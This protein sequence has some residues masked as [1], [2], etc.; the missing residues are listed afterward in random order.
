MF[1]RRPSFRGT[2]ARAGPGFLHRHRVGI[3]RGEETVLRAVLVVLANGQLDRAAAHALRTRIEARHGLTLTRCL[4]RAQEARARG[5]DAL[6]GEAEV[7]ARAVLDRA[8]RLLERRVLHGDALDAAVGAAALLLRAV[9]QVVVPAVR[10]R[11]EGARHVLYVDPGAFLHRLALARGKRP[12]GMVVDAP[13]PASLVVDRH[14]H[15]RAE[16]M[17]RTRRN[18]GVP[19]HD[20]G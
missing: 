16:R 20:P 4:R 11:D 15:V 14:P 7:L 5:D 3:E 1:S 2:G 17:A 9:D 10:K 6:V 18:D 8:H 12:V 19:G 13:G